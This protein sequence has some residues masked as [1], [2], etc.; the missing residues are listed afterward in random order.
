MEPALTLSGIQRR[1]SEMKQSIDR[2][3]QELQTAQRV[4]ADLDKAEEL[5][6][7]FGGDEG[8]LPLM[9]RAP[10]L[11]RFEHRVAISGRKLRLNELIVE[12]M[13]SIEPVW[14]DA[15]A[16]QEE[17]SRI[18]GSDVP[19]GSISPTLTVLKDQGVLERNGMKVALKERLN[20]A[21][22]E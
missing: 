8:T 15:V 19:M 22:Q 4:L 10:Q 3:Q 5:V 20:N 1:R 21:D 2:L 17:A 7:R 16:I 12:A 14:T 6:R 18:R 11:D 9:E 13:R